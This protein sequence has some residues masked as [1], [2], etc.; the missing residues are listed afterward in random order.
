MHDCFNVQAGSGDANDL[1][2]LDYSALIGGAFTALRALA[3]FL[4]VMPHALTSHQACF[5]TSCNRLFCTTGPLVAAVNAQAQAAMKSIAFLHEAGLQPNG[6][7]VNVQFTFDALNASTGE[8]VTRT[9]AFPLIAVL[10]VPMVE[11]RIC[12]ACAQSMI[13]SESRS[14]AMV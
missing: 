10:P 9:I 3:V 11:V 7:T 14:G 12:C 2:S 5:T 4:T 13:G 6:S 1:A 8:R